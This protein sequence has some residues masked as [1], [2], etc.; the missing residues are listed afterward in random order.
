MVEAATGEQA[1]SCALRLAE[2]AAAVH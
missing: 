2:V 1:K